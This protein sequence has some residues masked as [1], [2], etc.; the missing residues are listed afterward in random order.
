MRTLLRVTGIVQGVGFRPHVQQLATSLGLAGWISNGRN[1]V[2]IEVS[3]PE[4]RI[5]HFIVELQSGVPRPGK[6]A[7]MDRKELSA[8]TEDASGFH[9]LP[10]NASESPGT[11][12]PP[13][14]TICAE[15]LDEVR[16]STNR[17]HRYPFTC[18]A[19]CGPRF[20]IVE[21]LPYDRVRTTMRAFD[22]CSACRNE[23]EDP[24]DRRFHAEPIACA[25]CGPK[26]TLISRAGS[27]MAHGN[28]AILRAAER[29]R[30]GDIVA[31]RGIGGFQLL[32]VANEGSVVKKLRARKDRQEKPFAV[33]FPDLARIETEAHVSSA[34]RNALTDPSGPIVLLKRKER[35]TI[36]PEAAPRCPLLGAMLP[37]TALHSLLAEAVDVPL[38]CTSGNVS[39][40]PI[41]IDTD[42][43]LARL[44]SIA[45]VF[46]VHDRP[47]VRPVDDSVVREGARGIHILRRSRG[48]APLPVFQL[49]D[50]RCIIGLGAYM[51]NSVSLLV[52]GN[53]AMSQHIG[54]MDDVASVDLLETVTRDLLRFYDVRPDV[55]ACDLHP[56]FP[57]TRL[58]ERLAAEYNARLVRVQHHHAHVAGVMAEHGILDEVTALAWDGYGFGLDGQAWGG[59]VFVVRPGT[60]TRVGHL[61]CFRLPGGDKAA[62]EPRRSALGL[63]EQTMSD[64]WPSLVEDVWPD[65]S[66]QALRN[67]MQRGFSAP[68]TSSMGRLFDAFASLLGIRHVSSF[69]GQAA[70]E[71][72]WCVKE[73]HFNLPDPYPIPLSHDTP[74]I[75][76]LRPLV[77][78]ALTDRAAGKPAHEV[79]ARFLASIVDFGV[80]CCERAG[81][82]KV[83]LAGGCF[84]NDLLTRALVGRLERHGFDC[85][86]S[87]QVP[88]N[89]G[90]IS[91]GQVAAASYLSLMGGGA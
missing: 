65:G 38:I 23:Y 58:A 57:S 73:N 33:L 79:A 4:E 30:A 20:S 45:D 64:E 52:R 40:E 37:T 82:R 84:Q 70:M 14:Q 39:G 51:K 49:N 48:F 78:A 2:D 62:W 77:Q 36:A 41:C 61:Q 44:G 90:G 12:L 22:L 29:L 71:L 50:P 60:C 6:I 75:A 27:E 34:E 35:S 63:L 87:L 7:A 88:I 13:D 11:L 26:V 5:R 76:D 74:W 80:R 68:W 3:G 18:C 42:S 32:C 55:I 17:R 89:D 15:C 24:A 91:A 53:V 86:F 47:I 25:T 81:K 9:I 66:A 46:L 10:S 43:A 56:D 19:R 28:D 59:E 31:L 85:F 72:E 83:I 16:S 21:S 69:D 54:D 1:G 8:L 67:A